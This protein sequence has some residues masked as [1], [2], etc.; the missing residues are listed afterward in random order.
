MYEIVDITD[1][2]KVLKAP[3][4]VGFFFKNISECLIIDSGSS[5]E[6]GKKILR[7]LESQGVKHLT[8][9]NTHSHADHIGGNSFLQEKLKCRIYAT[10]FESAFIEFPKLEP[11]YLWGG[12]IFK[13]IDSK[14]L[15]A[16]PSVVTNVVEYGYSE[17]LGIEVI[18][19]HGHSFDMVGV[20]IT[21]GLKRV[22]FIADAVVPEQTIEKYKVYFLYDVK[23]HLKTLNGLNKWVE[24]VDYII[25][26]HGEIYSLRMESAKGY[27]LKLVEENR[28]V[29]DDVL[30]CIFH[31]LSE[32]LTIDDILSKI[33]SKFS[34]PLDTVAYVLLLQTLKAYCGY[35]VEIGEVAITFKRDR[36][37]YEKV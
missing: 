8:I 17:E 28:R 2:I 23:E 32:P 26:S 24:S 18:P 30:D 27:F 33:A 4:N 3:V 25:P 13:G 29:I 10:E 14:F 11:L 15:M 19:L 12:P 22:L 7:Y 35:L 6:Y 1:S 21:D 31:S 16:K 5:T 9:L 20:L 36:L 37:E 34:I